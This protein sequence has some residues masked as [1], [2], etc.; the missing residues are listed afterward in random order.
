MKPKYQVHQLRY[1]VDMALTHI[2]RYFEIHEIDYWAFQ[3]T[4][5]KPEFSHERGKKWNVTVLC[6]KAYFF[7]PLTKGAAFVYANA[8]WFAGREIPWK[9]TQKKKKNWENWEQK[10]SRN[11][12]MKSLNRKKLGIE[13][14][15]YRAVSLR[16]IRFGVPLL[17]Y[18]VNILFINT[19]LYNGGLISQ[20][21][22]H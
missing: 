4:S 6:L 19:A 22:K 10:I 18:I 1:G 14:H 17:I 5:F 21:K 2:G 7:L 9:K 11:Q 13:I 15:W 8:L 16:A 3:K 12:F 20:T